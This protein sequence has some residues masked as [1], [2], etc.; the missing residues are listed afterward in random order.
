MI[1]GFP[2]ETAQNFQE[3]MDFIKDMEFERLGAF[4]YSREKDTPAYQMAHQVLARIKKQRLDKVM[5]LQQGIAFRQ[6]QALK[7][8]LME[9]II[10]TFVAPPAPLSAS[11][12]NKERSLVSND[13][14]K[15]GYYLGRI[16]GDAP[17]VD[18]NIII[19]S[20][21]KLLAGDIV[22]IKVTGSK[23]YDL[24]GELVDEYTK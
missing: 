6:N 4:E 15:R 12:F 11:G 24:K 23:D 22:N 21:A 13:Q 10:D 19:K 8:R 18:G 9:A 3:L 16:Y 17:D 5:L 2:G 14:D 7:G 20:K 1:V